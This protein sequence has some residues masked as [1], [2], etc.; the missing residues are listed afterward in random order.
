MRT[1]VGSLDSLSGLRIWCCHE[2]WHRPQKHLGS[3]VAVAVAVAVASS[4]S[5]NFTTSLGTTYAAGA[6]LKRQN[7]SLEFPGSSA[8]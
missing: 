6:A 2:L 1:Q 4:Y 7:I 5:S 8:G 3:D